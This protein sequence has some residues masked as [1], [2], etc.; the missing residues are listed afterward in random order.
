MGQTENTKKVMTRMTAG[1][2]QALL[3]LCW[4][5]WDSFVQEYKKN[6]EM[7]DAVKA[8]EKQLAD[9]TKKKSEEAKGVL[10]R[11]S[12]ATDSGLVASIFTAWRDF[13]MDLKQSREL[14]AMMANADSGFKS[15]NMKQKNAANGVMSRLHRTEEEIF[16]DSVF[17]NWATESALSKVMKHYAGKMDQKKHQLEAVQT[18]F[19]SFAVQL[20]QGIGNAANTP[21]TQRKSAQKPPLPAS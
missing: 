6:K 15:L 5:A 20:E 4:Q 1:N 7:E 8:A 16:I 9:F 2:D 18:M 3:S 14:E 12:G 17:Q 21:R 19:K 11:M 10:N 13:F